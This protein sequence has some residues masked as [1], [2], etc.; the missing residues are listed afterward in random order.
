[1]QGSDILLELAGAVALL[2]WATRMVRTGVERAYGARLKTALSR[3]F[4]NR[5]TAACGGM[6]LALAL[7]SST[8]VVLMASGLVASGYLAA[9]P[10]VA[11]AVG[12]DLGSALLAV[13][14]RADLSALVPILLLVGLVVFRRAERPLWTH[15]GRILF[16]LGLLLLS[17]RLIGTAA[18]PL[19]DGAA[20]PMILS[21]TTS[22]PVLLFLIAALAAWLFHSTLAAVLLAAL[23]ADQA[24]LSPTLIGPV[25]LGINFGGGLIGV[26]LAYGLPRQG[27]VVPHA[28]LVLR[29]LW[30][31]GGLA[32]LMLWPLPDLGF[33]PGT[34][35]VAA[36]VAVN[37]GI[38]LTG[39]VLAGPL[40]RFLLTLAQGTGA[41]AIDRLSA[42]DPAD[43]ATPAQALRNA[44][45]EA[46]ALCGVIEGMTARLPDLLRE[47]AEPDFVALAEA[48]RTVDRRFA[49]IRDYLSGVAVTPDEPV[50]TTERM[51]LLR[52]VVRLEQVGDLIAQRVA[53]RAAKR[54]D[55]SAAFSDEGWAELAAVLEELRTT[56]RLAA[57]LVASGDIDLA[58][59]LV[60]QKARVRIIER[61]SSERHFERLREGRLDTLSSSTVHLDVLYDLKEINSL[62]VEI[63]YPVLEQE[64][65]LRPDRLELVEQGAAIH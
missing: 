45:R 30:S 61:Q 32:A 65:Q 60:G 13:I 16:G 27:R 12:A 7:Q 24:V 34:T 40:C 23:L 42:L 22:D 48:D 37:F 38:V 51:R 52:V 39:L 36:H 55:R 50:L 8:A 59:R 1:M 25:V 21:L 35:V 14:L 46:V 41:H 5:L 49:Q 18:A 19:R 17:L 47:G 57:N 4:R 2:V 63:G 11:A 29:A 10:A 44:G 26:A 9:V 20:V 62:L 15:W 54:R 3:A 64:G 6:A 58:R 56:V 53:T 43:L 31:A 28:N 33:G